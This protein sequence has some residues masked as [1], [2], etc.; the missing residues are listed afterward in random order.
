LLFYIPHLPKD[1]ITG[2]LVVAIVSIYIVLRLLYG[3]P[4][5]FPKGETVKEN[6]NALGLFLLMLLIMVILRII[7]GI[8]LYFK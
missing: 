8:G 2:I 4:E 1:E 6:F 7:L 5:L 3:R